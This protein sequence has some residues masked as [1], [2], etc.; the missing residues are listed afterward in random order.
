MSTLN[1]KISQYEAKRK[2][3]RSNKRKKF[4][5]NCYQQKMDHS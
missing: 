3:F 5:G 2:V 1:P 4:S